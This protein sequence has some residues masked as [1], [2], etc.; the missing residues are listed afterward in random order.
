M[1]Q[2]LLKTVVDNA[3]PAQRHGDKVLSVQGLCKAFG[4]NRV[5]DDISFDLHAGE[6]V[7]VIGRSGAGKSTLLHMLNGTIPASSEGAILSM[8]HGE[9]DRDVVT[10]NGR[11]MRQWR[12]SA[13]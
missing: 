1:A 6:L 7:A 9:A 4:D 5:L 13:A 2:A 11:Q 8:R 12:A 10:L 3:H